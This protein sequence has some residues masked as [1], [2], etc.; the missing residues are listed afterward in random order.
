MFQ[1][2][3]LSTAIGAERIPARIVSYLRTAIEIANA[4]ERAPPPGEIFHVDLDP[5][6]ILLRVEKGRPVIRIV[7][8]ESSYE[9]ARHSTGRVLRS[10]YDAR[11]FSA[12]GHP[13]P[14]GCARGS[15][16]TGRRP[17]HDAGRVSVEWEAAIGTCVAADRGI[18]QELKGILLHAV[19][20]IP[21]SR[22]P[23][24]HEF[25]KNLA[26]YLER[27]WPGRIVPAPSA[28]R[29]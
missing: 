17:V 4:L 13:P 28:T 3:P 19:D 20:P 16:L 14:A 10:S 24:V 29:S 18:D 6:N 23:S 1:E 26:G 5:M 22:Y 12:R 15:V 2:F 21:D 27:I 7:D 25:Q 11:V 8:F 9:W